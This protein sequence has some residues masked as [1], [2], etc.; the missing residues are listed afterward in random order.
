MVTAGPDHRLVYTN[1]A[2]QKIVGERRIGVPVRE[3]FSDLRQEGY[4][5]LLDQVLETGESLIMRE[6]PFEL[7]DYDPLGRE[8]FSTVS[9]SKIS[10]GDEEGLM[11]VTVDVTAQ[12]E[13]A[14]DSVA[15]GRRRFLQR[16]QSLLQL[17]SQGVWVTG[18]AGEVIEPSLGWQ[19]LTGQSWEEHRGN[20]WLDA[21]HPDDRERAGERWARVIEQLDRLDEVFR[22]KTSKGPYRHIRVRAVPVVEGREVIEWVGTI[23]D[24]EQEWREERHRELLDRAAAVTADLASLDEVLAALVDVIVPTVSDGCGIYVLPEFED[25]SIPTPFVAQRLVSIVREND[26]PPP[27]GP[28]PFDQD[29]DFVTAIRTRRPVHRV[30]SPGEPPPG[31]VPPGAEAWFGT[32][33]GNSLALVPVVVDGVVAAV[34]HAAVCGDREPLSEADVD[35]LGRMLDHA[36]THLSNAMRFQRTQRI[37]LALQNY[38]LPDPPRVPGLEITARYRPSAAAAEIGGDWYDSFRLPDGSAVLTVGDVA[39]HDLAAAVTMSQ[40]RNMLRGLAMD[41]RE[42]PGDILRRLNIA[43]ESLYPDVTATCVL[44]RL[45]GPLGGGWRLEYAV[46]GHPPPLLVTPRGEARY[47]EDGLSPLLGVTC[48]MPRDSATATLPPHSTLLLY[49]DGLV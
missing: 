28:Q 33:R 22:V 49:T 27:P 17:E 43:A 42:P 10:I 48:D 5:V 3:A 1:D 4:F 29:C 35:L 16:Y 46:A 13:S 41:R 30:F 31:A 19:R 40:L 24:V 20:G 37:A 32:A 34:V 18:Q 47:L 23:T 26:D 12:V 44:A 6:M 9:M 21:V 2:Y 7:G 45:N 36:H 14:A 15:E 39:G 11:L 38:L 25:E 8:R